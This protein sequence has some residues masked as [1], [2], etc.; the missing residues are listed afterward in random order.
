MTET[1]T[2]ADA[3][4]YT[5]AALTTGSF[6]PQTLLTLRTRDVRGISLGMYASFTAGVALW[7][8]Y[9]VVL[10]AWPI[11]VANAI[12]LVLAATILVTKL[13]VER[14]PRSTPRPDQNL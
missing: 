9:G 1:L 8:G 13:Q 6:L 11:V 4:G 7:L 5:A 2:L 12:T 10:Q 3:V 14:H